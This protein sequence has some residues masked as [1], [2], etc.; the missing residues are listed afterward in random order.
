VPVLELELEPGVD[1]YELDE[2]LP[3]LP[4]VD[5][6]ELEVLP[7]LEPI[8]SDDELDEDGVS[9][10]DE[11]ELIVPDDPEV[12]RDELAP[13]PEPE[14]EEPEPMLPEVVS[15]EELEEL[16]PDC[17]L[18][19]SVSRELLFAHFANSDCDTAPSLLVSAVVNAPLSSVCT[20]ASVCEMRP[21]RLASSVEND[22]VPPELEPIEPLVLGV[23]ELLLEPIEPLC[24]LELPLPELLWPNAVAAITAA[25]TALITGAAFFMV[26]PRRFEG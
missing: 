24:W 17:E 16:W 8:V 20:A 7:A 12:P 26:S 5:G 4:E 18:D 3:L 13:E 21:S 25:A 9:D 22:A 1:G 15:R 19:L 10:E 23:D 11:P 2:L 14:L 6:Y